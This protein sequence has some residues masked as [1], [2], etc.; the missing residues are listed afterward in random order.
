LIYLSTYLY[1]FHTF[2]NYKPV[3]CLIIIFNYN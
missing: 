2:I 3:N 1:L